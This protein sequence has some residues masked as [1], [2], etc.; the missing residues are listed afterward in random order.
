MLPRKL[1]T[2]N[3]Q[4]TRQASPNDPSRLFPADTLEA[5]HRVIE[6]G[7]NLAKK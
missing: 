5:R 2:Q 3:A 4:L 6:Y 7:A 1:D